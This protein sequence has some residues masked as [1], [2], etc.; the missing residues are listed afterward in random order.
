MQ[1]ITAKAF[2]LLIIVCILLLNF[3]F[4]RYRAMV[5]SENISVYF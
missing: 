2:V 5:T 3:Y 1:T 4:K